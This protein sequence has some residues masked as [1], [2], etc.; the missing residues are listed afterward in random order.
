MDKSHNKTAKVRRSNARSRSRSRSRSP[1]NLENTHAITERQHL[2]N[3]L[4]TATQTIVRQPIAKKEQNKDEDDDYEVVGSNRHLTVKPRAT[5]TYKKE[6]A[7]PR[8]LVSSTIRK[9]KDEWRIT[10][11]YS[12][13]SKEVK[14]EK[15]DETKHGRV[16]FRKI[17]D[18]V[19][20]DG[21]P[22]TTIYTYLSDGTIIKNKSWK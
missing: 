21:W 2:S 19:S 10:N 15:I 17:K 4:H 6:P 3:L 7:K 22:G 9:H 20:A 14:I 13:N 5:I 1:P 12:D 8:E 11:I 16:V 18:I